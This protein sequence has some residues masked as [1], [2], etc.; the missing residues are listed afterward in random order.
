MPMLI[1]VAELA[2][3]AAEGAL[4]GTPPP[5]IAFKLH[6]YTYLS[7]PLLFLLRPGVFVCLFAVC[8][9][10][11]V[12]RRKRHGAQLNLPMVSAGV[13]LILLATAR[14]CVDTAN[15]FEAFIRHDP[16]IARIGY[17]EDVTQ[18]LFTTKHSILV[19]VLLVGDSFVVCLPVFPWGKGEDSESWLGA[20]LSVLG[21]LGQEHLDRALPHRSVVYQRRYELILPI[22]NDEFY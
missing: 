17:L 20:E 6:A 16:R 22:P 7:L 9:Y 19:A 8:G 14:F 13:L 5:R 18:P 3:L 11:L 10:D 1:D 12:R 15:V 2:G 21:R 4:Y